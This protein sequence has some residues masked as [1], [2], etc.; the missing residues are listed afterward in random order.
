MPDRPIPDNILVNAIRV[1]ASLLDPVDHAERIEL[2]GAAAD[3]LEKLTK[4]YVES[5]EMRRRMMAAGWPR[6]GLVH[7]HETGAPPPAP[8]PAADPDDPMCAIRGPERRVRDHPIWV[9]PP[10]YDPPTAGTDIRRSGEDRRVNPRL[11]AILS[12]HEQMYWELW[13][14]G[15]LRPREEE[16]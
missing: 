10:T 7:P 16:A 14:A 9:I 1:E 13:E 8:P 15:L 11:A 3:R 12:R 2:L 5:E 4:P 6:E